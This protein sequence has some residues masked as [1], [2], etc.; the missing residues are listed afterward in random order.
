M[1]CLVKHEMRIRRG[2]VFYPPHPRLLGNTDANRWALLL[3]FARQT[4]RVHHWRLRVIVPPSPA[5]QCARGVVSTTPPVPLD[6]DGHHTGVEASSPP[7]PTVYD[8]P[9]RSSVHGCMCI[10]KQCDLL[11][12]GQRSRPCHWYLPP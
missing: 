11:A 7:S 5:I 6:C 1:R 8:R 2:V 3:T 10:A 12:L 4:L 9:D